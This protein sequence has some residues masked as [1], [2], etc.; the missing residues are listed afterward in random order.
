LDARAADGQLRG[1]ARALGWEKYYEPKAGKVAWARDNNTFNLPATTLRGAI[2]VVT[3]NLKCI[4]P[5]VIG[6]PQ[7]KVA[8]AAILHGFLLVP[9]LSATL[10]NRSIDLIL[11]GEPVEWEAAPYFMDAVASG[12][13]RAMIILGN[14]V[15]EE[16]GSG[17]VAAWIKTLVPDV[18]VE[19]LPAGEPF[20]AIPLS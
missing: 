9:Q 5:R 8:R 16:P 4:A 12:Q 20:R 14:E 2:H 10:R 19:H 13:K 3:A 7:L 17:E 18:P 11:C 1:L 15:S 6:D